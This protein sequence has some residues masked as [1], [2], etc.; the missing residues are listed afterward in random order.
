MFL[1]IAKFGKIFEF[2]KLQIF[3]NFQIDFFLICRIANV[4]NF[5]NLKFLELS[6]LK[7]KEIS[8]YFSICKIKFRLQKL[9]IF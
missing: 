2:S 7:N 3:G 8:R 1:K 5:P 6:K 4:W 9:A